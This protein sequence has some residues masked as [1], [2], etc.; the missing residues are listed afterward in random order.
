MLQTTKQ[1]VLLSV[2]TEQ[3][4]EKKLLLYYTS[5]TEFNLMKNSQRI[6]CLDLNDTLCIK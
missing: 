2:S 5:F 3:K 4:K 1:G 6:R